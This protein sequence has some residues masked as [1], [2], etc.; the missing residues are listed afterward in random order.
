MLGIIIGAVIR[1]FTPEDKTGLFQ[2]VR[3][4]FMVLIPMVAGPRLTSIA[5][6]NSS[7][8][9]I[10]DLGAENVLPSSMMFL[11][12]GILGLFMFSTMIPLIKKGLDPNKKI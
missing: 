12:A 7:I 8:T 9:Y 10:N 5:S 2:G 3:M 11:I 6:R 4:L 1:D